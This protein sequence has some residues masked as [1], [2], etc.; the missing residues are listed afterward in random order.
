MGAEVKAVVFKTRFLKETKEF[1]THSLRLK[2]IESSKN[3][4][5]IFSKGIR[6]LFVS[7]NQDFEVELYLHEI[8]PRVIIS[9]KTAPQSDSSGSELFVYE[10]LNKIKVFISREVV[11]K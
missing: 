8:V 7:S 3:H 4:F 10:D 9:K 6:L 2:T 11:K 5:V 1:Y